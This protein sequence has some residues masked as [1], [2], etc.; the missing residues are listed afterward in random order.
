VKRPPEVRRTLKKTT[1]DGKYPYFAGTSWETG[2]AFVYH[3]LTALRALVVEKRCLNWDFLLNKAF[4]S[5]SKGSLLHLG[6]C[7]K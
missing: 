2:K 7:E 6:I 1:E 4:W 3:S 5:P